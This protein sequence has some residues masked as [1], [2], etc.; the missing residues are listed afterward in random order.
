LPTASFAWMLPIFN[1][2]KYDAWIAVSYPGCAT[3]DVLVHHGQKIE[4]NAKG[5]LVKKITG[6]LAGNGKRFVLPEWTVPGH[7]DFSI[8]L[9]DEGNETFGIHANY[10]NI[11]LIQWT[12]QNAIKPFEKY[13]A[14]PTEQAFVQLGKDIDQKIIQPIDF[15]VVKP[16]AGI[17][18]TVANVVNLAI[19][20]KNMVEPIKQTVHHIIAQINT[21]S[22]IKNG[23]DSVDPIFAIF[24]ELTT[25]PPHFQAILNKIA[26]SMS[27]IEDIV[28]PSSASDAD[29]IKQAALAMH[30]INASVDEMTKKIA[31]LNTMLHMRTKA[32]VDQAEQATH[33]ILNI[34]K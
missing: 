17:G 14:K 30:G 19:M 13:V 10:T 25:L 7:R 1:N 34:I 23:K 6:V 33:E 31:R 22:T 27:A 4:V 32:I 2:T 3:D 21:L 11:D 8:A 16:I 5:C 15:N 9:M 20:I 28:R 12:N 29:K 24:Q 18:N 26:T